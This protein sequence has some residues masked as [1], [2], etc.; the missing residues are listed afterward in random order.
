M[1]PKLFNENYILIDDEDQYTVL[2]Y[3]WRVLESESLQVNYDQTYI[4]IDFTDDVLKDTYLVQIQ[5]VDD[6]NGNIN[7]LISQSI[8]KNI[9]GQNDFKKTRL[10][11]P[12]N[13]SN[14]RT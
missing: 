5:L 3:D 8:R 4:F 6:Y 13:I 2:I 9:N 7:H 11:N 1:K 14:D 10:F 12:S